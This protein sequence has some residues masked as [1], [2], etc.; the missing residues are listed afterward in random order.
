MKEVESK[1]AVEVDTISFG[2]IEKDVGFCP[3]CGEMVSRS[4]YGR[5]DECPSCGEWLE[6]NGEGE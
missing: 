1:H 4:Q 6:W 2:L 5:D 3:V